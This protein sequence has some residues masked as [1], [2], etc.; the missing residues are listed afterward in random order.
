MSLGNRPILNR[1]FGGRPQPSLVRA[2]APVPNTVEGRLLQEIPNCNDPARAWIR[3]SFHDCGTFDI[4]QSSGGCDGSLQFEMDRRTNAGL[5]ATVALYQS[6][7]RDFPDTSMADI[8][9]LAGKLAVEKCSGTTLKPFE[10]GRKDASQANNANLLPNSTISSQG[11]IDVFV[12]KYGYSLEDAIALI[13][14]GHSVARAHRANSEFDG[15]LDPTPDRL[16]NAFFKMLLESPDAFPGGARLPADANM[17]KDE[18]F[19]PIL[20]KF[21]QDDAALMTAFQRSFERMLDFGFKQLSAAPVPVRDD[22]KAQAGTAS[23][24]EATWSFISVLF[25]ALI[26]P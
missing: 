2:P 24:L 15:N 10:F 5:S 19:R 23:N 20:E 18:R 16:D 11:I 17:A 26:L 21:A 25:T 14:G 8:V 22:A 3:A 13:G 1:L 6:I 9:A 7:Q 12:D 4:K